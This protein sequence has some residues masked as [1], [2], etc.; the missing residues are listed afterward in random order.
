MTPHRR[1]TGKQGR[2]LADRLAAEI[3]DALQAQDTRNAS[4]PRDVTWTRAQLRERIRQ[5]ATAPVPAAEP[6]H[7]QM[8]E[9]DHAPL[10][11]REAEP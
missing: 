5:A 7:R 3:A 11:G 6:A 2:H 1:S 8:P 9:P 10:T 4:A